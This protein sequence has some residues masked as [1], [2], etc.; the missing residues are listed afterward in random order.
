MDKLLVRGGNKLNGSI[1]IGGSKNAV[2]PIMTATLI[3]PGNYKITNVPN[4]RDTKTMIRLLEI[5]GSKVSYKDNTLIV[6]TT[7]CNNP[8]APYELVKTM[9]ASFYVLGPLLSRFH[10]SEVS[11]PGGCAWGPRPVDFHIKALKEMKVNVDLDSGNIIASGQPYGA[12]IVFSKKSVGATGNVLMAA[13]KAIGK[14]KISNAS[15]EPEIV[16]LG[17]FL[18]QLGARL[19]GLGTDT[20]TVYP[21]ENENN[22]IDFEII[23][24]R[25][26]A[27]TFMIATAAV[28]GEVELK[29]VDSSH[30]HFVVDKLRKLGISIQTDENHLFISSR[31]EYESIDMETL[32]YPGFPT[33][34]QAQWMSLMIKAKG[35]SQIKENIYHDRYTHISELIR[36]GAQIKLKDNI[37]YIEGVESIYSAPVMCTDIRASA[38]LVISALYAKGDTEI[39]RIYHIDRGYEKIENKFSKIGGDIK[40]VT[41]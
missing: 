12:N 36:M 13:V 18:I 41:S 19:E 38:A 25:I 14:T 35:K 33:D 26:E 27:G 20:I 22:N 32:E 21:I 15:K 7:K 24:D 4:L 16:S 17:Q 2:L 34:L 31:G 37:A 30:L 29:K 39:S 28:G 9:R 1:S 3:V 11:L 6:D 8:C 10:H 5:I 23:P 40:R